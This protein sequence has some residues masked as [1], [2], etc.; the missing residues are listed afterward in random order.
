V[1]ICQSFTEAL[2]SGVISTR[3]IEATIAP[4]R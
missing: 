2:V 1:G 3:Y 4:R